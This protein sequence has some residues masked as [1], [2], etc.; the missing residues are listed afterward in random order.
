MYFLQTLDNKISVGQHNLKS[1]RCLIA[2]QNVL[3]DLGFQSPCFV[4]GS[5][6]LK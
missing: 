3:L 5:L 4:L 6:F 1:F 2:I